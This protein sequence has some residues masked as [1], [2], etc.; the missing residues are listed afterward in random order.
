MCGSVRR[1]ASLLAA[2]VLVLPAAAG[3]RVN[4][5]PLLW[6]LDWRTTDGIQAEVAL[7]WAID[8]IFVITRRR[9]V[10]AYDAATGVRRWTVPLT[11]AVCG[12]SH[13]ASGGVVAVMFGRDSRACKKVALI[14]LRK[15][16]KLWERTVRDGHFRAQFV[17]AADVMVA[18]WFLY[19]IAAFAL[20]D[21]R[22]LWNMDGDR[23]GC[24]YGMLAGGAVLMAGLSCEGD[25]AK[26]S[27]VQ[28]IDPRSGRVLWTY[29][30][31]PGYVVSAML[32]TRPVL[33][34]LERRST[35]DSSDVSRLVTL[36]AS[37][38]P[39]VHIDLGA[40]LDCFRSDCG[41][42]L[43]S[44]NTLYVGLYSTTP[45][46]TGLPP[47]V[48]YDL[49]TGRVRWATEPDGRNVLPLAMDGGRLM[50]VRSGTSKGAGWNT[51]P[52][53]VS[54]DPAT[55]RS[56]VELELTGLKYLYD[57]YEYG[58][59]RFFVVDTRVADV[60]DPVVRAY[61]PDR[62]EE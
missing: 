31:P 55:G 11:G 30:A 60:R 8:D 56:K 25:G 22:P 45:P 23:D 10:T 44:G 35:S 9:D 15:G 42:V 28:G 49:T 52:Q 62:R 1:W 2:L 36:D 40:E 33:L 51:P 57:S 54:V 12:G 13:R 58:G 41:E 16:A 20:K 14:D 26:A 5:H 38:V 7:S 17:V 3:G 48:A 18:D 34:G 19:G 47:L 27:R 6:T 53:I 50:V 32:S 39:G 24:T 21:G 43:V 37:G 46:G 61:G 4:H 59:G 29:D